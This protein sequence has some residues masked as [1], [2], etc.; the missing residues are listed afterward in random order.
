M[1]ERAAGEVL[2]AGIGEH[3][4]ATALEL[5]Q[6]AVQGLRDR[7]PTRRAALGCAELPAVV[8]RAHEVIADVQLAPPEVNVGP[9]QAQD[10]AAAKS[11]VTAQACADEV[12]EFEAR[13]RACESSV[14]GE[15]VERGML[16]GFLD[17]RDV[18]DALEQAP[19]PGGCQN[20]LEVLEH[21]V[22]GGG[23]ELAP[24]ERLHVAGF[25][26]IESGVPEDRE[27]VV[28][29]RAL[30][31]SLSC[32]AEP[33]GDDVV[34]DEPRGEVGEAWGFDDVAGV[35]GWLRGFLSWQWCPSGA[36]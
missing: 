21:A 31:G 5:A 36:V 18:D 22:G 25:D 29:D 6:G 32:G 23:R 19:A 15:V 28:V 30:V 17:A 27:Q 26:P 14:V 11:S 35:V 10:F 4:V 1:H 33:V 20:G 2:A 16:V 24:L 8:E 7:D 9:A 12:L 34:L 13:G 3:V